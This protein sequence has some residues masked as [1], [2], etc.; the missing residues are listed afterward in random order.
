MPVV[1]PVARTNTSSAMTTLKRIPPPSIV[2][3]LAWAKI[4]AEG[5]V[6]NV[7]TDQPLCRLMVVVC[8]PGGRCPELNAMFVPVWL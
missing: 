7:C 6:A 1:R 3:A 5:A 4:D 2:S 8:A